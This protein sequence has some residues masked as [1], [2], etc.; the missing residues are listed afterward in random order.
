MFAFERGYSKTQVVDGAL[1][2]AI[3]RDGK[4]TSV[5]PLGEPL[6]L[7]VIDANSILLASFGAQEHAS[8][9]VEEMLTA[10]RRM[11]ELTPDGIGGFQVLRQILIFIENDE[12]CGP[13]RELRQCTVEEILTSIILQIDPEVLNEEARV[14]FR[15]QGPIP[16]SDPDT[17]IVASEILIDFCED[18]SVHSA[19][20]I[21][22]RS[23]G[24]SFS[25][26]GNGTGTWDDPA[27]T[28]NVTGSY[29]GTDV[30]GPW[31]LEI[32]IRGTTVSALDTFGNTIAVAIAAGSPELCG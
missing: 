30:S 23:D 22:T 4:I 16:Q 1:A 24:E 13:L 32:T 31:G 2:E 10:A 26:E 6:N 11:D 15:A 12:G 29:T 3:G 8:V 28:G 18:G 9:R 7:I 17:Q 20:S 27:G 14:S 21:E 5:E 25:F 19:F